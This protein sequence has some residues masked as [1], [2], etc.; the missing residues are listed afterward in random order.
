MAV[1]NPPIKNS[2]LTNNSNLREAANLNLNQAYVRLSGNGPGPHVNRENG[3]K[4]AQIDSSHPLGSNTHTDSAG[5]E[6]FDEEKVCD[7]DEPLLHE[8]NG[9]YNP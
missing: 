5:G 2:H 1:N 3:G 4:I 9:A 7:Q 6:A 8:P